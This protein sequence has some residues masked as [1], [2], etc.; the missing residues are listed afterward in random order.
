LS[1]PN[2]KVSNFKVGDVLV[3]SPFFLRYKSVSNPLLIMGEKWDL[4]GICK[5]TA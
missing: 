2:V 3:D 5:G 4:H 1:F